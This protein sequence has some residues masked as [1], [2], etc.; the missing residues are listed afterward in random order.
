MPQKEIGQEGEWETCISYYEI[1]V[2]LNE[3]S[4]STQSVMSM[5]LFSWERR[6]FS[7]LKEAKSNIFLNIVNIF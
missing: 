4:E 5:L 3:K 1:N 2:F 7:F 6:A